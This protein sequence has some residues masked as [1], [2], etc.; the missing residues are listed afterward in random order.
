M[1]TGLAALLLLFGNFIFAAA[2]PAEFLVTS[3]V[4]EFDYGSEGIIDSKCTSN[5][6]YGIHG[7]L[8]QSTQSSESLGIKFYSS[9]SVYND[10]PQGP[11]LAMTETDSDGD[12]LID[13]RTTITY[14]FDGR[15]LSG[16]WV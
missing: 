7:E 4:D 2:G 16:A 8:L 3:E 5:N 12:G 6:S 11:L 13:L 10:S 1:K 15:E 9:T 14:S